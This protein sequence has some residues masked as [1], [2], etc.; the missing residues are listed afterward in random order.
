MNV[1]SF[2]YDLLVKN[3]AISELLNLECLSLAYFDLCRGTFRK[4]EVGA[5]LYGEGA[6]L[7]DLP[8]LLKPLI[9]EGEAVKEGDL[10]CSIKKRIFRILKELSRFLNRILCVIKDGTVEDLGLIHRNYHY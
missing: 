3:E 9:V 5:E 7:L 2:K 8:S 4:V 1:E 10:S 6:V